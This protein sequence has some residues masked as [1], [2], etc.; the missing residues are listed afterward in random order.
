MEV[1]PAVL[2]AKLPASIA[3]A[4]ER[5][6][7]PEL[8]SPTMTVNGAIFTLALFTERK[9]LRCSFRIIFASFLQNFNY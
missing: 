9:F 2:E 3:I 6:D 5:T 1:D 4:R 8:F 7:F